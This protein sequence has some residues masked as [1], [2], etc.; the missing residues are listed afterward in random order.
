MYTMIV[1]NRRLAV[2]IAEEYQNEGLDLPDLIQQANLGLMHAV[3]KFDY[4]TGCKFSTYASRW[5][6]QNLNACD[7]RPRTF[8]PNTSSHSLSYRLSNARAMILP[9]AFPSGIGTAL[10][11]CLAIAVLEP[12]H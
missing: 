1:C 3:K 8:D 6:Q 7:S 4:T 12:T 2:S 9:M 5:I 10:P 11:I